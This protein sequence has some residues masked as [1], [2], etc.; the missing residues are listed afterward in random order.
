MGVPD[1]TQESDRCVATTA[2]Y[3]VMTLN[4]DGHMTAQ[5]PHRTFIIDDS[6]P[7]TDDAAATPHPASTPGSG[8]RSAQ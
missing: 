8:S 1:V 2:P 7:K 4:R 6:T 5:G 3:T